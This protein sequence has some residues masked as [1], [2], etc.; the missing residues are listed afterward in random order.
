M[1]GNC[2]TDK[3][4]GLFWLCL[5]L[6]CL[7]PGVSHLLQSQPG[8]AADGVV[9]E[10][11][12]LH[13][14][15]RSLFQQERLTQ[16]EFDNVQ[17]AVNQI[18]RRLLTDTENHSSHTADLLITLLERRNLYQVIS[19]FGRD[20][21]DQ[22]IRIPFADL[23]GQQLDNSF[24]YELMKATAL[25]SADSAGSRFSQMSEIK[26]Q[27]DSQIDSV[28]FEN[29]QAAF[30]M[31]LFKPL[32]IEDVQKQYVRKKSALLHYY[33]FDDRVFVILVT[34]DSFYLKNWDLPL[35][36]TKQQIDSLL[37]PL[38]HA[39]DLLKLQFEERLAF[40]LYQKLFLPV[41]QPVK[42]YPL[43]IIIPDGYLLS[44]PFELLVSDYAETIKPED[45]ILYQ[46]YRRTDFLIKK[47][48]L[49]YSYSITG[50]NPD[51]ASYRSSIKL[52]TQL[53]TMSQ[54][55]IA[56]ANNLHRFLLKENI[57]PTLER[58]HFQSEEIKRVSRLLWRH[59]NLKNDRVTKEYFRQHGSDFRWIYLAQAGV[60][61]NTHPLKSGLLFSQNI[62]NG[63]GDSTWLN[64]KEISAINLRADMV[65]ISNCQLSNPFT[66]GDVGVK[67]LPQA[68]LIA[69][70]RSV[71]HS[72]WNI[73]SISTSQFMSKLYWELKYKRQYNSFALQQARLASMND[74]FKYSGVY[75]S[76]AHPFFWANYR[77][78]GDPELRPPSYTKIPRWA[79]VLV[80]YL[81]VAILAL[82][83][84]RKT[85][86]ERYTQQEASSDEVEVRSTVN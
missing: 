15:E 41:S 16:T 62:E 13:E 56:S 53:L 51:L 46:H 68:F 58:S 71:V 5:L 32:T 61:S 74:R 35:A 73:N 25:L 14:L 22:F 23:I 76:R 48:A 6:L 66:N 12:L 82:F 54:P 86:A 85:R 44:L 78:V 81:L 29:P 31:Q 34:P 3:N 9:A 42:K 49:V 75:I 2:M 1:M 83:I 52:G 40:Q 18:I 65:T 47:Y 27:I 84:V 37:T 69:G 17:D 77:L 45:K 63:S 33:L 64:S 55:A 7:L 59:V 28:C 39:D 38:Y 70:A 57:A 36:E 43:L 50:L 8:N 26:T 24:Q 20:E 4:S 67:G 30:F 72:L 21:S 79:V 19:L 80:V 60:M 11:T 10:M